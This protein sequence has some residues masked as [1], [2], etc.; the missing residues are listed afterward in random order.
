VHHSNYKL[1]WVSALVVP[2]LRSDCI[3]KS[4]AIRERQHEVEWVYLPQGI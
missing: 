2:L 3:I 1:M 4:V